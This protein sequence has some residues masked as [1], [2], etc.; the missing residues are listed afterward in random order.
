MPSA[1][2]MTSG[3]HIPGFFLLVQDG[4]VGIASSRVPSGF[5]RRAMPVKSWERAIGTLAPPLWVEKA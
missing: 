5:L 4:K 1:S 2:W 3:A